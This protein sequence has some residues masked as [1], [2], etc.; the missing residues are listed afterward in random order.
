MTAKEFFDTT[1]KMRQMQKLY[2]KTKHYHYLDQ[3]KQL[4]AKID[5]EIERVKAVEM[6][7]INPQLFQ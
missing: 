4:E 5:A 1:V 6:E 7:R 2:F 3:S